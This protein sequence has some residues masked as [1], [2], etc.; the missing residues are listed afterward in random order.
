MNARLLAPLF[1]VLLLSAPAAQAFDSLKI[2][3]ADL[4]GPGLSLRSVRARL[5]LAG[6]APALLLS[7][8]EARVNDRP[9]A[10]LELACDALRF[11]GTDW[12]CPRVRLRAARIEGQPVQ[13]S[14]RLRLNPVTGVLA[15]EAGRLRFGQLVFG[16]RAR[17]G[18]DGWRLVLDGRSLD[19]PALLALAGR[20]G[21]ATPLAQ[22]QGR[23]GLRLDARGQQAR[24]ARAQIELAPA[25]VGFGNAAGTLAAEGLVGHARLEASPQGRGWQLAGELQ[26][27]AGYLYADPVGV[28]FAE[29]PAALR[30]RAA[31]DGDGWTLEALRASQPGVGLLQGRG[32]LDGTGRPVDLDLSLS[33][34]AL[35]T[36]YPLYVQPWLFGTLGGDLDAAGRIAGT[37]RWRAGQLTAF[38]LD[39]ADG[40]IEDR[41]DRLAFQGLAARIAWDAAEGRDS[42]VAWSAGRL[43]RI[44]LGASRLRIRNEGDSFRLLESASIP[45]FDGRLVVD[46]WRIRRPG[47]PDMVFDFDAI[48]TP[49]S[50]ERLSQALDW[51]LLAGRLSGVV[52]EVHYEDGVLTVGGVLLAQAFDGSLTVRN[53]RLERPFGLV[54]R[55]AADIRLDDL[56]LEQL[57][58]TFSFG[59]ITGRLD[60]EV[61]GLRM[62][63]WRPVAFDAWFRTPED[64]RSRHRISQRA[65]N[66]LSSI[67][68]GGIG[69]ALSRGFLGLFEE[70]PY[71]RLGIG[72]RLENGVCHMRGVAPAKDGDYLV[73]GRLL[74]PR[75]DIIGYADEV[76]WTA[77][78][79]RLKAATQQGVP[80]VR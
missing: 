64:D 73:K 67:G 15:L 70:F 5:S 24:L 46:T 10:G 33:G 50:L 75:I 21:L 29:Y 47:R 68:G 23:L 78:V 38:S 19:A 60:G 37:A 31:G 25:G 71:D 28:D 39:L 43:Y 59:K 32:R 34:A 54:P 58:R 7:V 20:L 26:L 80:E 36:L 1:C 69:G 45:V 72:C 57:T 74:P 11:E 55:L 18:P 77:L 13:L 79:A 30:V 42:T 2:G 65:V 27:E 17:H 62:V 53:L 40:R 3:I 8:A 66:N 9:M 6:A 48:L 12:V 44:E 63:R 51:P 35:E 4:E 14:A 16:F 61:K 56:D 41:Q 22:A 52:P 76:D 49:V